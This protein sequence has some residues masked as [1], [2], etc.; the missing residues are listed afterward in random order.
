MAYGF[1]VLPAAFRRSLDAKHRGYLSLIALYNGK[2]DLVHSL[3]PVRNRVAIKVNFT[4]KA[5][6]ELKS[7]GKRLQE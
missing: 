5:M 1:W 7:L 6:A 4:E 2:M 3:H